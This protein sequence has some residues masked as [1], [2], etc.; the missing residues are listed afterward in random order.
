VSSTPRTRI[1]KG[2]KVTLQKAL[3][4]AA[5]AGCAVAVA[6]AMFAPSADARIRGEYKLEFGFAKRAI[7]RATAAI[8]ANAEGCRTWSVKPCR[9]RSWHR[10]DCVSNALFD[11][12]IV[13]RWVMIAVWPPSSDELILHRKRIFCRAPTE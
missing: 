2:E 11:E 3:K 5:I 4:R 1:A 10:V 13:C 8:C 6:A 7:A 12:G 9:R